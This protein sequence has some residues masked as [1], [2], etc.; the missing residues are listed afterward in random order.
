[1]IHVPQQLANRLRQIEE[2]AQGRGI[3]VDIN[4]PLA[5]ALEKLVAAAEKELAATAEC[6][7]QAMPDISLSLE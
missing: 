1:L 3:A 5:R 6:H 2:F 4:A 7:K